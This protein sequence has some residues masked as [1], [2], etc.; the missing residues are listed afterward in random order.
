VSDEP[1]SLVLEHLRLIRGEI[2]DMQDVMHNLQI[3]ITSLEQNMAAMNGRLDH[4]ERIAPRYS[5]LNNVASAAG[6]PTAAIIKF[7]DDRLSVGDKIE[8]T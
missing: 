1:A 2:A 8:R 6:D 7:F 3:R 4:V 5:V